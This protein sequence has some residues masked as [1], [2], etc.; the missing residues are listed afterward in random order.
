MKR[1][2]P[3]W[4]LIGTSLLFAAASLSCSSSGEPAKASSV[5][6]DGELVVA[7]SS[8]YQDGAICVVPSRGQD[9]RGVDLKD[10][11][12]ASSGGR[13][14]ILGRGFDLV[15][16]LEPSCGTPISRASVADLAPVI[17]GARRTAN[18]H[19]VAVAP[20][21]SLFVTLFDVGKLAFL[22]NGVLDGALDLSAYDVDGNP[23]AES[24]KMVDVAGVAKAFVSLEVLDNDQKTLPPRG[25]SLML[26]IDAATRT[27]EASI[28][29]LGINPFNSMYE[30]GPFLYLAVPRDFL[31]VTEERAGIERFDTRN[32]TSVMLVREADIGASV[33]QVAVVDGCGVAI[34]ADGTEQNATSLIRFDPDSGAILSGIAA[35]LLRSDGY[36][37]QGLAWRGDT[38]YVGDRRPV[39][40]GYPI[41][42]F[43]RAPGTC[44]LTPS[45]RH[46]TIS[47]PPVA[48]RPA[49]IHP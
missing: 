17:G 44:T 23:N 2:V 49:P 6:A 48:L 12:L 26:R 46:V 31:Q 45:D 29:L 11:V 14:F 4:L 25:E 3:S 35:P 18:P 42:V 20:D 9:F 8:D 24:V 33:A 10:P 47:Q 21:G 34:V 15:F 19:D 43:D 32:S 22:K 37:I 16:E 36:D 7:A 41:H 38:L 1:R 40:G 30:H 39:A 27:V 13:T 5:C 28:P